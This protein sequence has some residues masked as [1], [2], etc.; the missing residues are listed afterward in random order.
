VTSTAIQRK[1]LIFFNRIAF[2]LNYFLRL[3]EKYYQRP[4]E[5]IH[6][7]EPNETR[8]CACMAQASKVHRQCPA[9][10]ELISVIWLKYFLVFS[11]TIDCAKTPTQETWSKAE[12]GGTTTHDSHELN[13]APNLDLHTP[14]GSIVPHLLLLASQLVALASPPFRGRRPLFGALIIGLI[15]ISQLNPHFTNDIARAQPFTIGWSVYLSTLE[16]ILFSAHP[17][18]EASLWRI[19]KPSH[20]ALSYAGFGPQKLLWTSVLML[21]LRG[22]R[23]NFEVKNVPKARKTDK[24]T[25]LVTQSL[26]LV[27]YVLMTDLVVQLGIRMFYTAPGGQVGALNSKYVTLRHP[28][29]YWSFFKALVFGATPY[30]MCSMQ[31]T[32]FSVL[33]V[34]LG[35][36]QPPV[37]IATPKG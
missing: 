23:W 4:L 26:D 12:M 15:I 17:G 30:Y 24:R 6:R 33:A 18:P 20:E 22:I 1:S 7:R 31:Y 5:C 35:L 37:S 10:W 13:S 3:S 9:S 2:F 11:Y 16:K 29:W 21:N 28:E 14:T 8:G 32:I 27:Y 34:L 19:D 36:S 25:F